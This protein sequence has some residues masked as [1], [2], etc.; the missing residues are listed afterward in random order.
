LRI[1]G[2]LGA[3]LPGDLWLCLDQVYG[4]STEVR[5]RKI[6]CQALIVVKCISCVSADANE[7][8]KGCKESLHEA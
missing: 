1:V 3:S 7:N 8:H 6:N 4:E 2:L 5:T